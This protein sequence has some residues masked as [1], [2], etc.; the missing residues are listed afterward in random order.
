[1]VAVDRFLATR[2][3]QLKQA[4]EILTEKHGAQSETV[5]LIRTRLDEVQ[6]EIV[7]SQV[8]HSGQQSHT[9][10]IGEVLGAPKVKDAAVMYVILGGVVIFAIS[11]VSTMFLV[12]MAVRLGAL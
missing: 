8:D 11:G 10:D 7:E 9:T 12:L 6:A 2:E 4:V 1:M 5:A 3:V